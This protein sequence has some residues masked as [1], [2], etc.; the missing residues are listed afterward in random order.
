VASVEDAALDLRPND[1]SELNVKWSSTGPNH[2]VSYKPSHCYHTAWVAGNIRILH[3]CK[4]A[5]S[6]RF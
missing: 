5:L 4:K 1:I 2:A 3:S 6:L